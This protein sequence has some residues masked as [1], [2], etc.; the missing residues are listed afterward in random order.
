MT[1]RPWLADVLCCCDGTTD[2]PPP[3]HA[4][5]MN[6][7]TNAS[8]SERALVNKT[9][10][11]SQNTV[12]ARAESSRPVSVRERHAFALSRRAGT[13]ASALG[14]SA[15]DRSGHDVE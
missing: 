11:Y 10:L 5:R 15:I 13:L 1:L 14:R 4:V 3:P 2:L 9:P 12:V 7:A 8:V 6:A